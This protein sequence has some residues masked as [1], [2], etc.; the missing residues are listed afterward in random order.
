MVALS[1]LLPISRRVAADRTKTRSVSVM[2]TTHP[3]ELALVNNGVYSRVTLKDL[4][5]S[6]MCSA[7]ARRPGGSQTDPQSTCLFP[8]VVR[9]YRVVRSCNAYPTAISDR[10]RDRPLRFAM[11][12]QG[13]NRRGVRKCEECN[14]LWISACKEANPL[15]TGAPNRL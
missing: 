11:R 3:G 14:R 10:H 2:P 4:Q 9:K 7:N 12:C 5:L 8:T 6:V 15:Q 13:C 1:E